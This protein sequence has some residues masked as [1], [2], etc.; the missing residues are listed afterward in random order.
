MTPNPRR[1]D[2][3]VTVVEELFNLGLLLLCCKLVPVLCSRAPELPGWGC[4]LSGIN[5]IIESM[6]HR[7]HAAHAQTQRRTPPAGEKKKTKS[8]YVS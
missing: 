6:P 3:A 2:D 1:R 4:I 8:K 7:K 5:L